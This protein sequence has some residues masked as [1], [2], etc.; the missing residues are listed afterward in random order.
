MEDGKSQTWL[1]FASKMATQ[2]VETPTPIDYVMKLD[3]DSILKLHEFLE[4]KD[5]RLPPA[6]YNKNI[7]LGALRDKLQWY[8]SGDKERHNAE[9]RPR[10]ESHWGREHE[11]V[12]I[13]LAGQCYLMS[14]GLAAFVAEEAPL[15]K[16]RVAPGGYVEGVEDHDISAMVY[17]SPSPISWMTIGKSQ[18]FWEHPVKGLPRY[19]KIV[20]REQARVN[21]K[22]FEGE[23]L[24]FYAAA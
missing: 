14:A 6:P 17:H 15:S 8:F 13:Y 3:S 21:R 10:Y 19:R 7:F 4:F 24:K 20:E 22:P 9:D 5:S 11:N 16:I 23:E 1:Y 18:R 12:H 2:F